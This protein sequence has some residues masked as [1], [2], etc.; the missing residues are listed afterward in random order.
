MSGTTS[1]HVVLLDELR[2]RRDVGRILDPRHER[3]V[4]RVPERGSER[5]EVGGDRRR[6]RATEGR[7]DVDALPGAGE[8]DGCHGAQGSPH[9]GLSL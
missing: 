5:V 6:A 4:V 1:L 8:E 2:E 7:D 9:R 3:E